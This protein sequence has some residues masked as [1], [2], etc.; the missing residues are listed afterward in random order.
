[1]RPLE[2]RF[3][4]KVDRRG[5]DECWP[6]I[7]GKANGYG[8]ISARLLPG[9]AVWNAHRVS[10]LLHHGTI[11][12]GE[13]DH[14]CH[15]NDLSCVTGATCPHRGCVNPA[16]LEPV[17]HHENALRRERRILTCKNGHPRTPEN[18]GRNGGPPGETK[19]RVCHRLKMQNFRQVG[20]YA[21]PKEG[22][23]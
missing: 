5:D 4:E 15:T 7:G 16:H 23:A 8:R 2:D 1:M 20:V 12:D 14:V 10:Y 13:L 9:P 19:C 11:P 22:A 6:W 21:F 18:R 17:T 3:W